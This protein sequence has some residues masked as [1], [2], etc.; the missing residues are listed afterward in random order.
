MTHLKGKS[1]KNIM[2][3]YVGDTDVV[4]IIDPKASS[5]GCLAFGR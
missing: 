3:A 1:L 2:L 5:L 4:D